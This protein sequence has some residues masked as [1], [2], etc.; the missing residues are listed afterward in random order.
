MPRTPRTL[1][2]AA[3]LAAAAL[4]A[5]GCSSSDASG[6]EDA[7]LDTI[8]IQAPFLGA[9]PPQQGD[10]VE[11]RLEEMTG[12]QIE[13]TWVPN[14]SYEDKTNVTLAG[15]QVPTVMVIQG[16]TP[17]FVKNAQ[18]GAFW[19]LTDVLADYPNL[20]TEN[21]EVQ[22]AASV[23]G[24]VY[25]IYRARDV[26]RTSVIVRKDWLDKLGLQ[27]PKTTEDLANV[28]RAFTEDD[29]D[30]NG[31]DDTSGLIVPKW[32]GGINS[33]SPWDVM[34]TW[35]GAGNGW[36]ERDG[37]LVP[38]FTTPEWLEAVDYE[39]NLIDNG[40]VNPDYATLD[41]ASWNEPFFQGKGGII[42][43]VHSRAEVIRKLFK[44]Q[45]PEN[46]QNYVDSTGN[47][48]GPDGEM[49]AHPTTGYSGF[50]VI[51]KSQVRTEE[52]LRDVLQFLDTMA[53]EDAQILEN[54]GIEGVNFTVVDGKAQAIDTPEAQA[55]TESVQSWAQLGTNV[56]GYEA[57]D[58][59]MATEY[60]QSEYDERRAIE[61]A[62]ME[63]AVFDEA[64]P[65]V[66]ETYV[67]KG[68]QLDN[69]VSDARL[70]YLAG[71]ID[72]AALQDAIERWRS[73]GGDQIIA[74]IN[75]LDQENS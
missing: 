36:T 15:D 1:A 10:E 43:D 31:V 23:N 67:L 44:Q 64:A 37:E 65:Y 41:S 42:V 55:L 66:S 14:S 30:G 8:S 20:T 53:S 68:A 11:K 47:L 72:K 25:G 3:A 46:F 26:M 70:Q 73:S 2:A 24:T 51:P 59:K 29:P 27:M 21:P 75:Q 69:I 74:E 35:F 4:V 6:G 39:K 45:D 13:V 34:A 9:Q 5:S 16:K 48:V 49:H 52:Q 17:G 18:A 38:N 12:K 57:Y 58:P 40:W 33:N 56:A 19:D 7:A 60:E 61:E 28:A 71:Q 54:N 62:D 50:L 63:N 32:P 22:E